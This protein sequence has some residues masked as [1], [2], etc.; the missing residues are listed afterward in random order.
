MMYVLERDWKD[1]RTT[2][3]LFKEMVKRNLFT[4]YHILKGFE[5]ILRKADY[6]FFDIPNLWEYLA[7]IISPIFEEGIVKPRIPWRPF[8]GHG[9]LFGSLL[10]RCYSERADILIGKNFTSYLHLFNNGSDLILQS[11]GWSR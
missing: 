5:V 4:T 7:Q 10:C 1:R 11:I 9:P 6:F 2:G 8:K 3:I